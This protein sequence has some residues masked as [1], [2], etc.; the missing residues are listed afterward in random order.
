MGIK[1]FFQRNTKEGIPG[2]PSPIRPSGQFTLEQLVELTD[3]LG[4]LSEAAAAA[5]V[6]RLQACTRD[7]SAWETNPVSVRVLTAILRKEKDEQ[8]AGT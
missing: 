7:G 6:T 1:R 3:A 8:G 5:G 2:L 4:E